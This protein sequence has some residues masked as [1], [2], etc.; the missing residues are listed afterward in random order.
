MFLITRITLVCFCCLLK[1]LLIFEMIIL[2]SFSGIREG[3]LWTVL[4]W[5]TIR[6]GCGPFEC[7]NGH[8]MLFPQNAGKFLTWWGT[9]SF[10]RRNL[11][12][13]VIFSKIPPLGFPCHRSVTTAE[14]KE[15][16]TEANSA[17]SLSF[18]LFH[19]LRPNN[20]S[21]CTIINC[22]FFCFM[23]LIRGVNICRN[24]VYPEF[25]YYWTWHYFSVHYL[26]KG[27]NDS[28]FLKE[29]VTPLTTIVFTQQIQP[30]VSKT[31]DAG[32]K[33]FTEYFFIPSP[34]FI[35]FT[36]SRHA[37]LETLIRPQTKSLL[38]E[39]WTHNDI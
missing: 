35:I 34:F 33:N 19:C 22:T 4:F 36:T 2:K 9:A 31:L 25:N 21:I 6:K 13:G 3:G 29:N 1:T 11:L 20:L 15:Q 8:K 7:G 30:R 17:P 28:Y 5:L 39:W 10:S 14:I 37:L 27:I 12:R 23:Q 16:R 26:T 24:T 38:T 18:R 32:E